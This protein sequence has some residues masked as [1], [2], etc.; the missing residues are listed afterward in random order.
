VIE[1]P[2]ANDYRAPHF[3]QRLESRVRLTSSAVCVGLD[4]RPD[5][6]PD[7]LR[8]PSACSNATLAAA[9]RQFCCDIIDVVA[10][11][12]PCV[13]PQ[14]A[15]FEALGS[16]GMLALEDVTQHAAQAGLVVIM[17]AKRGDIG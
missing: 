14:I 11:S 2:T 13:K 3:G 6:L 9:Y 10:P 1:T 16:A 15:F 5:Q 12:V 7:P 4:P 8:P 17:D